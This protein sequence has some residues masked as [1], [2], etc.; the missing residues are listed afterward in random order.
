MVAALPTRHPGLWALGLSLVLHLAL[1]AHWAGRESQRPAPLGHWIEMAAS[2]VPTPATK[3]REKPARPDD[4]ATENAK[5]AETVTPAVPT[6]PSGPLGELAGAAVGARDRY[7]YELEQHLNQH[8]QYPTRARRLGL[9]GRVEV[10][11]HLH[12]DGRI[13]DPH[14]VRPCIHDILN[15]AALQTVANAGTYKPFPPE[16]SLPVLHVTVPI[17]YEIN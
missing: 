16:I 17:Q 8:K 7:L 3:R 13:T 1:F 10:A 5:P 15:E 12:H 9:D 6:T 14:V 2:A 11:F 4:F